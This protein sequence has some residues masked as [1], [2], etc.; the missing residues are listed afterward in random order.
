[1]K[2]ALDG[3]FLRYAD[4]A[5]D[6]VREPVTGK[7][8]TGWA[9]PAG[10]AKVFADDWRYLSEVIKDEEGAQDGPCIHITSPAP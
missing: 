5:I 3:W 6:G 7:G 10:L 2:G 4:P 8:Q 1:M 9:G